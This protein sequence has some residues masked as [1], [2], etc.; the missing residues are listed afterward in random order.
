MTWSAEKQVTI[1]PLLR[2][3]VWLVG[4]PEHVR[5]L[6]SFIVNAEV[7]RCNSKSNITRRREVQA[8]EWSASSPNNVKRL[9]T[10]KSIKHKMQ[11]GISQRTRTSRMTW[12]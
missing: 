7:N 11:Y 12:A 6:L 1:D 10:N 8:L 4:Q 3:S 2:A 9:A 5:P